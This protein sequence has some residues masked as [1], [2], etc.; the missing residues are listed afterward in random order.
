M[1]A[2]EKMSIATAVSFVGSSK[3]GWKIVMVRT[4]GSTVTLTKMGDISKDG[5]TFT[6]TPSLSRIQEINGPKATAAKKENGNEQ[7]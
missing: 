1:K 3:K 4:V 7:S 5:M 2:K 6:P